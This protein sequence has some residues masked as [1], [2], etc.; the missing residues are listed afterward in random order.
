MEPVT[1]RLLDESDADAV[2][3]AVVVFLAGTFS[4]CVGYWIGGAAV[5]AGARSAGAPATYRSAR[6]AVAFA[7]APIA[8]SLLLLW[9]LRLSL[10]GLDLFRTGGSDGA[11]A[12]RA[13]DL[14]EWFFGAWAL[15]LLVVALRILYGLAWARVLAALGVSAVALVGL[16]IVM[17]VFFQGIGGGA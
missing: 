9:P 5:M 12:G 13:F 3:V 7:A 10:Y 16:L 4:G 14:A 17:A 6:H 1:G 2:L 15:A 8:L 11:G